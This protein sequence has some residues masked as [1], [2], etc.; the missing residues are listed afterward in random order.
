ME[1]EKQEQDFKVGDILYTSWGYDMTINDYCKIIKI[2]PTRKTVLCRMV[3]KIV[4]DDNGMGEGRSKATNEEYGDVF[5]LY[6]REYNGCNGDKFL[7][8]GQYP[9]SNGAKRKGTFLLDDG[10][11]RYYNTWD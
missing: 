2:S 10:K 1:I 5:R 7:F 6:V 11:E 3:K 8:V 4:K 9:F